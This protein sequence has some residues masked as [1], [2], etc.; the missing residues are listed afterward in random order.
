MVFDKVREIVANQLDLDPASITMDSALVDDLK[1]DSLDIVE[2]IMDLEQE[3]DVEIPDGDLPNVKT[4][5][6]IVAF[7]EK[8]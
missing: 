6:D 1:A 5:G 3:F 2:L 7:L 8:N 4:I